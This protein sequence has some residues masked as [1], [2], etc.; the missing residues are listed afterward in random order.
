MK[1]TI[2]FVAVF[3]MMSCGDYKDPYASDNSANN[4][5]NKTGTT[6]NTDSKAGNDN[7]PANEEE[8]K[9]TPEQE[10]A[11]Q[12]S[13]LSEEYFNAIADTRIHKFSQ[14]NSGGGGEGMQS[15]TWMDLCANGKFTGYS[16]SSVYINGDLSQ[17]EETDRGTWKIV[18]VG[19]EIGITLKNEKG[20]EVGPIKIEFKDGKFYF[21]GERWLRAARGEENGPQTCR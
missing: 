15:T 17:N 18:S 3:I 14:Y 8:Q 6:S 11:A 21:G 4:Q 5:G 1:P 7:P 13:S 9:P 19:N 10:P 2:L 20:E 12:T 16:S